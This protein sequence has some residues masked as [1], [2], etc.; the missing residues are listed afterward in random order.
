MR[1]R[2]IL[3]KLIR[4]INFFGKLPKESLKDQTEEDR[5]VFRSRME[6]AAKRMASD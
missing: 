5:H 4:K 2:T 6:G 3:K 1:L